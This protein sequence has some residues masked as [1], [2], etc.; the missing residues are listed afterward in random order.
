[1]FDGAFDLNDAV[2]HLNELFGNS[3]PESGAAV[4]ARRRSICLSKGVEQVGLILRRDADAGIT[5]FE[6]EFGMSAG[7]LSCTKTHHHFAARREFDGIV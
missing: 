5:D 7:G 3:Q 6:A 1:M 2:H 4:L